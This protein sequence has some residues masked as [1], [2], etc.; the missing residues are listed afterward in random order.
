MGIDIF[1]GRTSSEI[2]ERIIVE[3]N[4]TFIWEKGVQIDSEDDDDPGFQSA[5]SSLS[6]DQSVVPFDYWSH[7]LIQAENR[8]FTWEQRG[9][10]SLSFLSRFSI[11]LF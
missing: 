1:T 10:Y 11:D 7:A 8:Y 9:R 2:D 4:N 6:E 5:S 3:L